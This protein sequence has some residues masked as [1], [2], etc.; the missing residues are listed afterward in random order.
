MSSEVALQST[1]RK[2][3]GADAAGT[4]TSLAQ[5][6][7][8]S[9]SRWFLAIGSGVLVAVALIGILWT[10]ERV[11]ESQPSAPMAVPPPM[12]ADRAMSYLR[13]I[14]DIGPRPSGSAGMAAQQELLA[15]FFTERGAEVDFQQFP[16]RHPQTGQEITMANLI[17]RWHPTQQRR[18]LLCAHYDTRPFPDRD[19]VNPRGRFVGAN[20]GASGVAAMMEL[21]HVLP[22]LEGL[23]VDVVLFDGEEL[24]YDDRRDDYF[25]GSTHFAKTYAAGQWPV[26]YE[27]G[28][29]LDMVGD[30][31][32]ELYYERNS[33][34]YASGVVKEVWA[35]AAEL[36]VTAFRRGFRHEVRDDHLPLNQIA[37][38]PTADV[39]DFDYPR[40]G[41]RQQSYW[42]TQMDI[43]ENCSGTSV[44][45]VAAVVY[46]WLQNRAAAR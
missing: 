1:R 11:G 46:R 17:A 41:F 3:K 10:T 33:W 15:E 27:A 22:E 7:Q 26:R 39:I 23:G 2:R 32:L 30:R 13:R 19:P 43:P 40:P 42:H 20:D 44:A 16:V 29:L 38:I 4:E 12:D 36:N 45:S 21:S 24:V 25:L 35:A 18:I 9:W 8:R 31:E 14:A 28:L 5:L 6:A 34:R 37:K